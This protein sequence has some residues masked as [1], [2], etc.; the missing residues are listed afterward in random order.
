M[1]DRIC[2]VCNNPMG[3]SLHRENYKIGEPDG[4]FVD[5]HVKCAKEFNKNPSKFVNAKNDRVNKNGGD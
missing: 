1:F 3:N 5:V 4:C 2:A